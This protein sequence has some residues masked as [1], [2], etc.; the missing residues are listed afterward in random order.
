LNQKTVLT[1]Q[2]P[3]F[4]PLWSTTNAQV[5]NGQTLACLHFKDKPQRRT[6]AKLLTRDEARRIESNTAKLPVLFLGAI[7]PGCA[8][9]GSTLFVRGPA[10]RRHLRLLIERKF[11]EVRDA[12]S[13]GLR[14]DHERLVT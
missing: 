9:R 1:G 7:D 14:D 13:L 12:A 8:V 10:L 5:K 6:S 2:S 4:C 3:S 11:G